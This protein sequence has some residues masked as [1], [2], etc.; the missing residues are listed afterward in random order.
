[1]RTLRRAIGLLTALGLLGLL[2]GNWP[3]A[4]NARANLLALAN[5]GV[6]IVGGVLRLGRVG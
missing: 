2:V 4:R 3:A 5:A 6:S 1:M